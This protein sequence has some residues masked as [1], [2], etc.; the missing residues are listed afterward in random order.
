MLSYKVR[1]RISFFLFIIVS[2]S[3]LIFIVL[4]S[5]EESVVYFFSPTEI[6]NKE[7][8]GLFIMPKYR[9]IDIN[10]LS[11]IKIAESLLKKK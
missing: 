10:D 4:R 7:N 6:Y 1:S 3:I 9:S 8:H 5:L 11:E 2:L